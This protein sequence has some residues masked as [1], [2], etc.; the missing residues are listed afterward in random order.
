MD[1]EAAG[2]FPHLVSNLQA[3]K[4]HS[5]QFQYVPVTYMHVRCISFAA[6]VCSRDCCTAMPFF[7]RGSVV[8]SL[9]HVGAPKAGSFVSCIHINAMHVRSH[10]LQR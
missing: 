1:A 8:V 9:I 3:L 2:P 5:S 10:D 6:F 4:V 7:E